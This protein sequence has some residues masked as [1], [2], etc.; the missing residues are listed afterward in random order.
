MMT[1]TAKAT[2]AVAEYLG[3]DPGPVATAVDSVHPAQPVAVR[4]L[5]LHADPIDLLVHAPYTAETVEEVVF[6]CWPPRYR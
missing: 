4:V 5:T 3:Y 6:L 1:I 2:A